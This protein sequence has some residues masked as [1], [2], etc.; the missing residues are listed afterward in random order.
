MKNKL[1]DKKIIFLF[2]VVIIMISF[3]IIFLNK[4]KNTLGKESDI[5]FENKLRVLDEKQEKLSNFLE[6]DS[7]LFNKRLEEIFKKL[8]LVSYIKLPLEIGSHS[9]S[10]P[11]G[12]GQLIED[13]Q[14]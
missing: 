10:Y 7:D 1:I 4:Q 3:M 8:D 11:F 5:E 2:L 14:F 12:D 13:P 9:N 6:G